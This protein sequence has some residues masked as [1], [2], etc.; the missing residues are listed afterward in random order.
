LP[1][2]PE[3]QR[4]A[5]D[6][7]LLRA[8]PTGAAP[9]PRAVGTATLSVLRRCAADGPVVVAVD[10]VQWLDRASAAAL[11]FALRRLGAGGVRIFAA[12]RVSGGAVSDP[13]GLESALRDRLSRIRL[14]PLTLGGLPHLIRAR[15]GR[16]AAGSG[17][18]GRAAEA[19]GGPSPGGGAHHPPGRRGALGSTSGADR[20]AG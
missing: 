7:A 8:S 17:H 19:A 6:V 3:P 16:A 14:S 18:A 9:N 12:A 20:R 5:L 2:L 10:D 4:V 13:L 15:P 1:G 11:G